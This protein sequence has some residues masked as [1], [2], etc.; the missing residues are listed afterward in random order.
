[1]MHSS[2]PANAIKSSDW[3]A[4][5]HLGFSKIAGKTHLVERQRKGP[6]AVQRALYPEQDLCHVYLLH[7]PGGVAGGDQL[8]INIDVRKKAAALITTPGATKFYRTSEAWSSQHQTLT[9]SDGCLEWLPQENIF[10]PG[11]KTELSTTVQLKGDATFI[12]WE[13]NCLGRP[14][15][16]E[17]FDHGEALFRFSLF[18]DGLP[19]LHERLVIKDQKDLFSCARLRGH[20]VIGTLYATTQETGLVESIRSLIPEQHKDE[21]GLTQVDG[22]FIARY[23]GDSTESVRTLFCTLWKALRPA[24]VK[25]PPCIPRIWHT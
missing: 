5:L 4:Q 20:P 7:P 9:V 19:L 11:A 15:V 3:L 21:L 8:H 22:L 17:I 14:S 6:L 25:R 24:V 1:M 13:I 23:L 10:F 12:G 16:Q 2:I 18:R